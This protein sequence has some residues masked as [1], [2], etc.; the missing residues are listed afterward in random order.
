MAPSIITSRVRRSDAGLDLRHDVSARPLI[1]RRVR[2]PEPLLER[3]VGIAF[4]LIPAARIWNVASGRALHT[5]RSRDFTF[6]SVAARD[7]ALSIH[8]GFPGAP[9][10]NSLHKFGRCLALFRRRAPRMA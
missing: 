4:R 8:W 6:D 3:F 2:R 1:A 7:P 5:L 9:A 10:S